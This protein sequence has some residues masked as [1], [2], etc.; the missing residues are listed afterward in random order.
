MCLDLHVE[1]FLIVR[2]VMCNGEPRMTQRHSVVP[3]EHT[4]PVDI[5]PLTVD[6]S[7][8]IIE[9]VNGT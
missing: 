8:N 5:T 2:S 4:C 3:A 7:D 6:D 9:S 1:M